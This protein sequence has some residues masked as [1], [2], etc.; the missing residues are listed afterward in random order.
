[1]NPEMTLKPL[2]PWKDVLRDWVA[3]LLAE[4]KIHPLKR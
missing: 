3:E 4:L 1:M 2:R